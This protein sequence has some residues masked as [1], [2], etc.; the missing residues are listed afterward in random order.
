[1]T[2]EHGSGERELAALRSSVGRLA[3]IGGGLDAGDLRRQAYPTEWAVH[4]VLSHLGSAA[5]ITE[6]RIDSVLVAEQLDQAE[7]ERIWAEWNAKSPEQRRDDAL[8]AE[9]SLLARFDAMTSDE[10]SSFR[11]E[12]GPLV[13]DLAKFVGLRVN[14]HVLHSWDIAV[15]FDAAAVIPNDAVEVIV[16][17]LGIIAGFVAKPTGTDRVITIATSAPE[18]AFTVTLKPDAVT[19]EAVEP[20]AAA[21]LTLT[22]DAFVRLVYGRLDPQ[23]T[24]PFTGDAD[25][26]DELRRVF[27]GV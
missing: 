4:G 2:D 1:M 11:F 19:F 14:E 3:A 20:S 8:A 9:E 22:A 12:M 25:V 26:L 13:V 18:R 7:V 27:P 15:T 5:E 17:S 16:D 6:H 24:P 10:R 23:H 21:D